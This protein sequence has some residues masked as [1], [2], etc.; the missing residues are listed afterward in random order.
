[1]DVSWIEPGGNL[2]EVDVYIV[3]F[4]MLALWTAGFLVPSFGT[5]HNCEY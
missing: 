3:P 5:G 4:I 1:M 2:G